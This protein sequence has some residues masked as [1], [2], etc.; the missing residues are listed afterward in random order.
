MDFG[1][2]DV[3]VPEPEDAEYPTIL[4][5]L[6]APSLKVYSV[7]STIAEKFEAMVSLGRRNSRMKDFHD[8]WALSSALSFEGPKLREAVVRCFE[9][10]KSGW[11]LEIP[12]A[13]SSTL[14]AHPELQRLWRLY[15]RAGAFRMQPPLE[16]EKVGERIRTFLGPVRD[17]IVGGYLFEKEWAAG[18]GWK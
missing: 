8:M 3:I 12:E 1:L 2:G 17:S 15:I 9:R 14:Y 13:L 4:T 11:T 6:P 18:E 10:R 5:R 7:V 16:F